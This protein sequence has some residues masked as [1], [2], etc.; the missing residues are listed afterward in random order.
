M[1]IKFNK[2]ERVAGLFVLAAICGLLATVLMVAI[3]KGWFES[4]VQFETVMTSAEG[5]HPGTVVQI[6]GLRAGSVSDVELLSAEKIRVRFQ[7][8]ERFHE[9]IRR[10]SH[11]Q[12]TRPFI[13]GDKVLEVTVGSETE[14]MMAV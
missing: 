14:P 13:I 12:V 11:M 6:A 1:K 4:K 2:F 5:I 3:K 7:V 10:D 9:Q 8:Y